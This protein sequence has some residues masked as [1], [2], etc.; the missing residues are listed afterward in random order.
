MS[1]YLKTFKFENKIKKLMS[2]RIDNEKLLD[3]Y[4]AILKKIENLKNIKLNT[5]PVYDDRCIKAK[6]RT[7]CDKFFFKFGV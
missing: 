3:K 7:Y 5:L 4:K 1:G 6:L 2:F